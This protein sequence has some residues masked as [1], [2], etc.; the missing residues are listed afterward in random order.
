MTADTSQVI[1]LQAKVAPVGIPYGSE[2]GRSAAQESSACFVDEVALQDQK[3][4]TAAPRQ[5]Q[6]QQQQQDDESVDCSNKKKE[7][8]QRRNGPAA[9]TNNSPGGDADAAASAAAQHQHPQQQ[10]PQ[11]QQQPPT[12]APKW[13]RIGEKVCF[14]TVVAAVL[15]PSS[16]DLT[17][18]TKRDLWWQPADYA[19]FRVNYATHMHNPSLELEEEERE[20]RGA[21]PAPAVPVAANADAPTATTATVEGVLVVA[22]SPAPAPLTSRSPNPDEG[23]SGGRRHAA[24]GDGAGGG[25]HKGGSGAS[26][27]AAAP[28]QD[29]VSKS[30]PKPSTRHEKSAR[31]RPAAQQQQQ[32]PPYKN[33]SARHRGG[34]GLSYK[35]SPQAP[36]HSVYMAQH[37]FHGMHQHQ[38]QQHQQAVMMMQGQRGS[39]QH[40]AGFGRRDA[41]HDPYLAPRGNSN[42]NNGRIQ[43]QQHHA[44]RACGNNIGRHGLQQQQQQQ[45]Q[46][47]FFVNGDPA[48][49]SFPVQQQSHMDAAR[50]GAVYRGANGPGVEPFV[51]RHGAGGVTGGVAM[52]PA[53]PAQ[54]FSSRVGGS[55]TG[56]VSRSAVG[57][58]HM[59]VPFQACNSSQ[60]SM[61]RS[62]VV[63][64][65]VMQMQSVE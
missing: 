15:I 14:S 5:Q 27:G 65:P 46:Q 47:Q 10:E 19:D 61:W 25:S 7:K 48:G 43:P 37:Q 42:V 40:A 44:G 18:S 13:V 49:I 33:A 31:P 35:A 59:P 36:H 22:A 2:R 53:A 41:R 54:A 56:V 26:G 23:V 4:V 62:Q 30:R 58:A 1:V 32:Q 16:H 50:A 3:A 45:Q 8:Q 21:G 9:S 28:S 57:G 52:A 29:R 39:G 64:A 63:F 55:V 34:G 60:F 51:P 12:A 17:P 6:Q 24:G 20:A 11:Q 38:H